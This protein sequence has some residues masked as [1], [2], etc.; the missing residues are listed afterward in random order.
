MNVN[1]MGGE[2]MFWYWLIA[3]IVIMTMMIMFILEPS[4]KLLF[5]LFVFLTWSSFLVLSFCVFGYHVS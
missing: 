5:D 3:L 4:N 2:V 1:K